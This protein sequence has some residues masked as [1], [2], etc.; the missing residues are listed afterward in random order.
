M[1]THNYH[2]FAVTNFNMKTIFR[3]V[4]PLLM[5]LTLLTSCFEEPMHEPVQN[6]GIVTYTAYSDMPET[7]TVLQERTA[8]WKGEEWIQIVGRNGNY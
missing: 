7:K 8:L 6:T 1:T 2:A 5:T 3:G 4:L